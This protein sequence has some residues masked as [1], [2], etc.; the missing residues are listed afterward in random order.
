MGWKAFNLIATTAGPDYL[1]TFPPPNPAKA[2]EFLRLLGGTYKSRGAATFEDALYPR[3]DADLYVGA[4][5]Q[6]IVLG[7]LP[8][9]GEAFTGTVPRAV[10]CAAEMLPGCRVLAVTL[11]SVVNLFGYA[12]FEDG[13]LLRARAGSADQGVFF[14][15]GPPLPIEQKLK[16]FDE[17]IDGEELVMEICRPFLG[18]RIDEYDAWDLRMEL[19]RKKGWLF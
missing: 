18:C 16:A 4:Y 9:A 13:R 6:A 19:F 8:I 11:H 7:S 14:E 1:T 12:W 15:R 2:R 3:H 5:E 10:E 17:T